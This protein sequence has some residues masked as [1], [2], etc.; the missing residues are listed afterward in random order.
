MH[1][2]WDIAATAEKEI[3][4]KWKQ[5]F[6]HVPRVL[7]HWR[8][9]S[10]S[11]AENPGS[12]S[13]AYEAGRRAL[14]DYLK[15]SGLTGEAAST[16]H[17]GFYKV[18]YQPD[19]FHVR[20]EIGACGG[21]VYNIEHKITSG[22]IEPDGQCPFE[23]M[24]VYFAGPC[25]RASVMQDAYALDARTVFLRQELIPFYQQYIKLPYPESVR[26]R[27]RNFSNRLDDRIWRQ[28]SIALSCRL[29]EEGYLLLWNPDIQIP[30]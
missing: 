8:C 18:R 28:R 24:P 30:E 22:M 13:Y 12:K 20:P 25:N 15:Y 17:L 3:A 16:K 4:E 26:D 1:P 23:N 10:N 27:N 9:H 11:T 5:I 14:Q 21:S 19:L 6:R 2:A 29:R 7:Y